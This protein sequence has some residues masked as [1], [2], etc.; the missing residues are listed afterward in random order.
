MTRRLTPDAV[1]RLADRH[2]RLQTRRLELLPL[3]GPRSAFSD[4]QGRGWGNDATI[5][6]SGLVDLISSIAVVGQLQPILVE[7]LEGGS[8]RIVSGERRLR[9]MRWGSIHHPDNIHFA[10]IAAV[11][12]AGPLSDEERRSWQLIENL[13]RTDLQPAELAAALLYERCA[14]LTSRLLA[15]GVVVPSDVATA[16]DPVQRFAALDKL[17]RAAGLHSVGAPWS[18]VI[19]R[20]GIQLSEDKAKKLVGAFRAIPPEVSSEMDAAEVTLHSRMEFLKL[21]RGRREA[22]TEIWEALRTRDDTSQLL[23][24]AVTEAIEHP[25][26]RTGEVVAVA[27]AFREAA[28]TARG[29]RPE[30]AGGGSE[31]ATPDVDGC[32]V[33][34]EIDSEQV[35]RCRVVLNVLLDRL[36]GGA[37]VSGYDRGSLRL[38]LTEIQELLDPS[39]RAVATQEQ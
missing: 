24:R 33:G 23:T 20:I 30:S 22:A 21:H 18:E 10:S 1:Y 31:S 12:V 28:R 7:E 39:T 19:A 26:A 38:Q 3:S 11:I 27:E 17:R 37:T 32:G 25:N 9:A 29:H 34:G 4:T 6:G 13:A 14:V 8:H 15:N 16:D 5:S 35:A 36:R 2:G